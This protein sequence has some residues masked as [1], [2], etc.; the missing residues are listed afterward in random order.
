MKWAQLQAS[1][2]LAIPLQTTRLLANV[3]AGVSVDSTPLMSPASLRSKVLS[4]TTIWLQWTDP[5]IG[6]D[7]TAQDSR[8]YNVHYEA[9]RPRGKA[10]SAV[11]RDQHVILYNL[12]PATR[13]EFRVRTVKGTQT[14]QYSDTIY[15]STFETGDTHTHTPTHTLI[16]LLLELRSSPRRC[17]SSVAVSFTTGRGV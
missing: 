12:A 6:T 16:T 1:F 14:S 5:S 2:E 15:N 3:T 17:R 13:Y 7:Q 4:S 8:Y 10:L 9:T 11:A